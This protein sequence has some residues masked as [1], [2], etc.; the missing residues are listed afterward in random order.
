[1]IGDR[2]LYLIGRADEHLRTL[3]LLVHP[4]DFGGA[5]ILVTESFLVHDGKELGVRC[6]VGD[7]LGDLAG[8]VVGRFFV[9]LLDAVLDDLAID[10]G[11]AHCRNSL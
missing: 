7:R 9:R 10:F 6:L 8:G 5:A 11:V 1:M 4:D 2:G 3:E